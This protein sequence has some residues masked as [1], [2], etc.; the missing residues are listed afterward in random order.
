[1]KRYSLTLTEK[2]IDTIRTMIQQEFC[3]HNTHGQKKHL[4]TL[5]DKLCK[6]MIDKNLK[7][8]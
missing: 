2:Q 4:R 7:N 6:A 5:D 1:M 3:Y 8:Q